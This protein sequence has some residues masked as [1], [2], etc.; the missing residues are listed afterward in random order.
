[1]Y[2]IDK[3]VPFIDISKIEKFADLWDSGVN[4]KTYRSVQT[5][6]GIKNMYTYTLDYGAAE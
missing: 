2:F 1:M 4:I 5:L 6:I 3:I